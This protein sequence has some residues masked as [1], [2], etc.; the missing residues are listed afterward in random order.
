MA[1][2]TITLDI[3]AYDLLAREKK[4]GQSFSDVVKERLGRRLTA[5][6]LRRNLEELREVPTTLDAVDLIIASRRKSPARSPKL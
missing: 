1:T 6:T 3:E 4:A 5:G 2:K